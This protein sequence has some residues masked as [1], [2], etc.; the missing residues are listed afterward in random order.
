MGGQELGPAAST[1]SSTTL[2]TPSMPSAGTSILTTLLFS[3]PA[4]LGARR[5]VRPSPGTMRVWM[6]AGVLSPVFLRSNRGSA[7]QDLRR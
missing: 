7:T 6:T 4:P 2:R 5:R 3:E 1:A